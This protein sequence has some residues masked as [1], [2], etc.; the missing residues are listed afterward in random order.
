MCSLTVGG[1]KLF[2]WG[3]LI[4]G[5]LAIGA[6]AAVVVGNTDSGSC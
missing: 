6:G 5:L 4:G 3:M 1:L 2:A